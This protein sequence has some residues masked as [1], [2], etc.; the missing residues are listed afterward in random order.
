MEKRETII[1]QLMESGL[2]EEQKLLVKLLENS[3]CT[4]ESVLKDRIIDKIRKETDVILDQGDEYIKRDNIITT[5][6]ETTGD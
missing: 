5:V 4:E 1:Q 2:N 3:C 6:L